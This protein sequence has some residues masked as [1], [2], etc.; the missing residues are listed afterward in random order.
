MDVYK[1]Q[2]RIQLYVMLLLVLSLAVHALGNMAS[3]LSCTS[4]CSCEYGK[5]YFVVKCRENSDVD[6]DELSE[7]LDSLLPLYSNLTVGGFLS[8]TIVNT[9]L[10]HVPR[11][12]C[13]LTTLRILKLNNNQLTGLPDDCFPHLKRLASL[14]AIGNKIECYKTD[15]LMDSMSCTL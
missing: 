15:F 5:D 11:S 9:P 13:R 8:L 3:N 4:S 1:S 10:K 6:E 2:Y 14:R 7:K 12:V